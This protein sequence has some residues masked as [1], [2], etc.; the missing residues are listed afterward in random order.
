MNGAVTM[1]KELAIELLKKSDVF[2]TSEGKRVLESVAK[3]EG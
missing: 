2:L 3:G 1:T